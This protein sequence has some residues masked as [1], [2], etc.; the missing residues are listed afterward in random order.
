MGAVRRDPGH[1]ALRVGSDERRHRER[2]DAA[3]GWIGQRVGTT[4]EVARLKDLLAFTARQMAEL[5]RR[6]EELMT[7]N[8]D[9]RCRLGEMTLRWVDAR[10][11]LKR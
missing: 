9:L 3:P 4:D 11:R 6:N 2:L 1:D 8:S 5:R 10:N 7:M